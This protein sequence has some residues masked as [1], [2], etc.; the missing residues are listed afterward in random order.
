MSEFRRSRHKVDARLPACSRLERPSVEEMH[1]R[2]RSKAVHEANDE[3]VTQVQRRPDGQ[4]GR[5]TNE[6]RH[7]T[8]IEEA[9]AQFQEWHELLLSNVTLWRKGSWVAAFLKAEC[10]S[11][12]EPAELHTEAS[13]EAFKHRDAAEGAEAT[14]GVFEV[15]NQPRG[16]HDGERSYSQR[17]MPGRQRS[18]RWVG[19]RRGGEEKRS[20]ECCSDVHGA[21]DVGMGPGI[22]LVSTPNPVPECERFSGCLQV[23]KTPDRFVLHDSRTPSSAA[24]G[25]S[26]RSLRLQLL[27]G[28]N[29]GRT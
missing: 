1:S 15:R 17:E 5:H 2:P 25:S 26:A 24:A 6:E 4:R 11:F 20:E 22:Q 23:R 7:W 18:R 13:L 12:I 8:D 29:E 21:T 19:V 14:A 28:G 9:Q 27:G 16:V 3:R 10:E